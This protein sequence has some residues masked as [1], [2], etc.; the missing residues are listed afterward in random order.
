MKSYCE[1][2]DVVGRQ[3]LDSRCFPTVEVEVY[4]EDGTVGRAAVPSGAS[5]GI[6]EA[7]E[8]RDGDKNIYQGKSVLKAVQNINEVIAEELI[9]LNVFEQPL[10]DKTLIELDGSENKGKLGANAI[11]G[12]SLACAKAAAEITERGNN[13]VYCP[14]CSWYR[15]RLNLSPRSAAFSSTLSGSLRSFDAGFFFFIQRP[16]SASTASTAKKT[17]MNVPNI[18]RY[19]S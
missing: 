18:V 7:V 19:T 9:G 3:I 10:I 1:I 8:L 13:N 16:M 2:I 12:V 4:L 5:T 14:S 15:A 6:Y 17:I 11:L